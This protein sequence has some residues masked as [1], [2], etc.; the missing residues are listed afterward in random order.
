MQTGILSANSVSIENQTDRDN[1]RLSYTNTSSRG[2]IP[3]SGLTRHNLALNVEHKLSDAF[4][5]SSSINYTRSGSDNVVA[6]NNG[7]VLNDVAYLSPSVDIRQMKS[8]WLT[9][10]LQQ[11]KVL[12]PV[13]VDQDPSVPGPASNGDNNPW[14]TLNQVKNSF[15]R[16]RIFGNIKASYELTPHISAFVRYSQDLYAEDRETKISKSYNYE[17]NGYYSN[18]HIYNTESNTDFLVTYRNDFSDFDLSASAGGNYQYV[19]ASDLQG[20]VGIGSRHHRARIFQCLQHRTGQSEEPVQLF[21]ERSLQ[22]LCYRLARIQ[23][24][25]LSRS[26]RPQRL[27]Q[28]PA[29][30]QQ[31]LFLS[32]CV[33]EP[34]GQQADPFW[35]SRQPRQAARRMGKGRE[36]HR[37]LQPL[38][39][40]RYQQLW[41]NDDSDHRVDAEKPQP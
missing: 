1:Y 36:G 16:N 13:G 3:T 17:K 19:Y 7:G 34:A 29:F 25:G 33:A 37:P 20:L 6:G 11:R 28:H 40:G 12:P 18:E 23:G 32:L 22:P 39:H 41:R 21:E 10:G 24:P 5:I 8:Y 14:F 38:W 27:V 35:R 15:T 4:R 2:M 9:P 31:L 26:H 30:Q